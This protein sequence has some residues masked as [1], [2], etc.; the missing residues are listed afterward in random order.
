MLRFP[1]PFPINEYVPPDQPI[2]DPAHSFYREQYQIND[3]AMD[4]FV[5][6]SDAGGLTMGYYDM[7]QSKLWARAQRFTL[8]DRFFHAGFGGSLLNHFMLV[9]AC[10]PYWPNPPRDLIVAPIADDAAYLDDNAVLPDDVQPFNYF[11]DVGGN[12]TAREEHLKDKTDFISALQDGTLP[13][14]RGS[15]PL[16]WP[17]SIPGTAC[18]RPAMNTSIGSCTRSRRAPSGRG[19]WSSS[20]TTRTVV[21]GTTWRHHVAPPIV[22]EWGPGTRIPALIISPFARRGLV[23]HTTYDTPS[24]LRF[25]E[26]RWNLEPLGSRDAAANSFDEALDFSMATEMGRR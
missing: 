15:S 20:P 10:V 13:P 2:P 6:W 4:Q 18:S 22:D 3:G 26:W 23:D 12:A 11:A 9:C 16:E 7:R 17:T 1:N 25:I 14:S 8:A 24:I 21:S 19:P 5:A